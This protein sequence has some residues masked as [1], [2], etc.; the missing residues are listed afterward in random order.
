MQYAGAIEAPISRSPQP[1]MGANMMMTFADPFD[2]LLG[3]QRALDARLASNWLQDATA[4]RGPFPP[5]NVFQQG[6]DILAIVELPGVN[7]SDLQVQA[8]ENTIRISGRKTI[9]EPEGVS[10]HRRERISGDFDR[11]LTMPVAIDPGGIKAEYRDGVLALFLPRAES[12]KPRT[13]KIK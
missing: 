10:V 2:A 4:S 7:K 12:A 3:L 5:M 9:D 8:K 11:T 6:E 13:I 1:T